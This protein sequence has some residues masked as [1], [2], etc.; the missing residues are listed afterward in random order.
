[1]VAEHC[2]RL[3]FNRSSVIGHLSSFQVFSILN[4]TALTVIMVA[5]FPWSVLFP[6]KSRARRAVPE[7]E[8]IN[9]PLLMI[10]HAKGLFRGLES[11]GISTTKKMSAST[12]PHQN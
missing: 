7:P 1:M 6:E 5:T 2:I 3:P 11:V 9:L 8:A 12:H 4:D 10:H